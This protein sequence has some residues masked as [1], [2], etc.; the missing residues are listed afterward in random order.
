MER[1]TPNQ[2]H[3]QGRDMASQGW[4]LKDVRAFAK[5]LKFPYSAAQELESGFKAKSQA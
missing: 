4:T 1:V 3:A 5:R 2:N